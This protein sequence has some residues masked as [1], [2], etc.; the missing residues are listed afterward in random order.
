LAGLD[1]SLP[2]ARLTLWLGGLIIIGAGFL[3]QYSLK[4][5]DHTGSPAS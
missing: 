1:I 2:G 3:A 4:G 5:R